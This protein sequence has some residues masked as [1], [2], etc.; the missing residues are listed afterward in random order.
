MS[1]YV[2]LKKM[3]QTE[4]DYIAIFYYKRKKQWFLLLSFIK[5][6]ITHGKL[7]VRVRSII[8]C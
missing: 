7:L 6:L 8:L 5:N 2:I 3:L 1:V 4:M